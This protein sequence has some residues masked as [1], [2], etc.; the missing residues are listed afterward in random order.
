VRLFVAVDLP[1]DV[2]QDLARVVDEARERVGGRG[3]RWAAPTRWHLTLVFL[4]E[5]EDARVPRLVERLAGPA[6]RQPPDKQVPDGPTVRV[7]GVGRF[8]GRVLWA[9]VSGD[10][11]RVER[12]VGV[13]TARARRAGVDLPARRW[14]PH[15]TLARSPRPV[16]LLPYLA[17]LDGLTTRAWTVSEVAMV[18]SH[19]GPSPYHETVATWPFPSR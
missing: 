19:L 1:D 17:A 4:G 12:V 8:D 15:I 2:R 9:D 6:P 3:L 18:R 7:A 16:D 11:D 10:I 13:M 5:I 14:R